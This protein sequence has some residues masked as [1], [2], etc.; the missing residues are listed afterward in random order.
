MMLIH[1]P[2]KLDQKLVINLRQIDLIHLITI[3][4]H[5][6][7]LIQ[8]LMQIDV[9]PGTHILWLQNNLVDTMLLK[10]IKPPL[11]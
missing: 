1:I 11:Q 2:A 5:C 7:T 8:L 3:P 4:A 6:E 10:I 9:A